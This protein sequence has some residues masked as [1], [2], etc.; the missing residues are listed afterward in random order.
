MDNSL[1]RTLLAVIIYCMSTDY[2]LAISP[3]GPIAVTVVAAMNCILQYVLVAVSNF[4]CCCIFQHVIL[5][6]KL[7]HSIFGFKY[8]QT[9]F[10]VYV[11]Q[12][13]NFSDTGI[14]VDDT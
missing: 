9:S 10:I 1:V 5:G 11:H 6:V 7:L 12:I 8:T 14:E 4:M 2:D 3:R 13:N